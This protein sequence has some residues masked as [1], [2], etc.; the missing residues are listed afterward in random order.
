MTGPPLDF[1]ESP[2]WGPSAPDTADALSEVLHAIHLRGSNVVRRDSAETPNDEHGAGQ[3]SLHIVERGRLHVRLVGSR[4]GSVLE[5]GEMVLLAH[6]ESHVVSAEG[7]TSWVT[8]TFVVDDNGG[9]HL[10]K[11]LPPTIVLRRDLEE[12]DWLGLSLAL[13]LDEVTRPGPGSQVMVSRILDLLFIHALRAWAAD[14]DTTPGWL[15]AAMDGIL[16]PVISAIHRDPGRDWTVDEM[17][18]RTVMSRSAFAGRFAR[19]VGVPPAAYV[20]TQRLSRAAHLLTSTSRPVHE[21][22]LEVGYS[23]DAAF[24]RAFARRFGAPPRQWRAAR[25]H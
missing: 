11:V 9:D 4:S 6:G 23:S 7:P 3:R 1:A 18:R 24:S 22:A 20:A 17:A 5:A 2:P 15:T 8:G 10:F 19:L 21:I 25:P 13:L 12:H 14:G 16:G